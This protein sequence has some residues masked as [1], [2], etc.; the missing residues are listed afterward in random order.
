M[1]PSAVSDTYDSLHSRMYVYLVIGYFP[2]AF[3]DIRMPLA[4]VIVRLSDIYLIALAG[5]LVLSGREAQRWIAH[6]MWP[7]VPFILYSA[8]RS[9]ITNNTPGLLESVQWVLTLLWIPVCSFMFRQA[10]TGHIKILWMCIFCVAAYTALSHI[11]QGYFYGF[12]Q[13]AGAKYSFGLAVLVGFLLFG[14]IYFLLWLPLV[15]VCILLLFLSDERKGL[16]LNVVTL[17]GFIPLLFLIRSR[18]ALSSIYALLLVLLFCSGP[19]LF[20]GFIR[21]DLSATHFIDEETAAWNSDLHRKSLIANGVDIFL[22]D[23]IAGVGPKNLIITMQDYY[24]DSRLALSTHN[25][26]LDLLIEYGLI[27]AFLILAPIL[28]IAMNARRE[29]RLSFILLPLSFYCLCVPMFMEA[30]T[31]T[32]ITFFTGLACILASGWKREEA[33]P[34]L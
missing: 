9:V 18:A 15:L 19:I 14:R 25:F 4:G 33:V 5:I 13:M 23:P 31:F 30:G 16:L 21:G 27:G 12:K 10:D 26:Y 8:L 6:C 32:T 22:K 11:H 1:K 3:L 7:F 28:M 29:H 20:Y 17:I 34:H 24:I 2:L